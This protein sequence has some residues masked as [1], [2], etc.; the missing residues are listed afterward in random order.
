M[1]IDLL[2]KLFFLASPFYVLFVF[3]RNRISKVGVGY[4]MI[5]TCLYYIFPLLVL[6]L[7]N[8]SSIS[9]IS[10]YDYEHFD[11]LIYKVSSFTFYFNSGL[12]L[13]LIFKRFSWNSIKL[14]RFINADISLR[15]IFFIFLFFFFLN[16]FNS[17]ESD[18]YIEGYQQIQSRSYIHRVF[19]IFLHILLKFSV[20]HLIIKILT[21]DLNKKR[22]IFIFF[23][24]LFLHSFLSQSRMFSFQ[25]FLIFLF[26]F[27][28]YKGKLKAISLFVIILVLFLFFTY[29]GIIR[30]GATI[31]SSENLLG[32][33]GALI[34]NFLK[35]SEDLSSA[36]LATYLTELF[37][38]L[39][40]FIL[41]FDKIDL[42]VMLV[43]NY[44]P[45][46]FEIGGGMGFGVLLH[47]LIG[48][49]V[50]TWQWS[51]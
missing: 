17:T 27:Y 42:S 16:Q 32:E 9:F 1:S 45:G 37:G 24:F 10:G 38:F 23:F 28:L 41:P 35:V 47:G 49:G 8:S 7:F 33:G 30:G 13:S 31:E 34:L 29:K 6:R 5:L 50:R 44:Y 15:T 26:L 25:L 51:C 4:L 19:T 14:N 12:V 21:T 43:S 48:F 39:P 46:I 2:V 40:S 20:F 3:K 36:N 11:E 22:N 18:T